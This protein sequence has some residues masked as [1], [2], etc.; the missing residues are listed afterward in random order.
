MEPGTGEINYK[1]IARALKDMGY[2]GTIG[3]EAWASGDDE[4]ALARFR[5]A[6][7]V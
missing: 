2:R 5:D 4:T 1:A 7:T 3:M 6:F